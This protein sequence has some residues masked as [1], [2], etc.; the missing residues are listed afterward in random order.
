M[1]NW[2]L[3]MWNLGIIFAKRHLQMFQ[4]LND[5][6]HVQPCS[7][8]FL[9]MLCHYEV[10]K[11]IWKIMSSFAILFTILWSVPHC[12]NYLTREEK[13]K[14]K[15][16]KR[17]GFQYFLLLFKV[18]ENVLFAFF[19]DITWNTQSLGEVLGDIQLAPLISAWQGP[20]A[21]AFLVQRWR[22]P[23]SAP[24]FGWRAY[25]SYDPK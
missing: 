25:F 1:Q 20:S 11:H 6:F 9:C 5:I 10:L 8:L 15:Q 3:G 12:C 7:S 23:P 18:Y 4:D 24:P 13:S 16:I 22:S 14:T 17:Q 21:E 19:T 2:N